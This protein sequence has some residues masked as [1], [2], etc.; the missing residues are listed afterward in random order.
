MK[1]P[2]SVS[3]VPRMCS[4]ISV[5]ENIYTDCHASSPIPIEFTEETKAPIPREKMALFCDLAI[6]RIYEDPTIPIHQ[7]IMIASLFRP[8]WH[9]YTEDMIDDFISGKISIDKFIARLPSLRSD[10]LR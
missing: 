7:K 1:V 8:G 4:P 10:F 6:E 9:A 2:I 5:A 3:K